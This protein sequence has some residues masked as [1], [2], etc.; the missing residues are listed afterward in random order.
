MTKIITI[1]L[2]LVVAGAVFIGY[3]Q[4]TYD[5]I[6]QVQRGNTEFDRA[7]EK[8]RE[9]QELKSSL[10]SRFNTFTSTDRDRLD[11]LLPDHVDN[12]RLILDLDS[13]ASRYGMAVQNVV[14]NRS[15]D[16]SANSPDTVIG[17]LGEQAIS[18][19]SLTLQFSSRATYDSF[20]RFLEDLE[21]SLRIV[22]LVGLT[23]EPEGNTEEAGTGETEPLYRFSVTIRTYW[24]K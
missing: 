3:T 12:V 6:R 10:L 8:A 11:K 21:T 2:T 1:I 4:P 9:L 13:L 22:D 14:I 5:R 23:F 24:L 17:A 19:D 7:L 16:Q 18:Y 15:V 20:V